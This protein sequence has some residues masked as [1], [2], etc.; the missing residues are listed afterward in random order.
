M[1]LQKISLDIMFSTRNILQSS[2]LM[3]FL[4]YIIYTNWK[5]RIIWNSYIFLCVCMCMNVRWY[6]QYSIMVD[7]VPETCIYIEHDW[8]MIYLTKICPTK[9]FILNKL[10][11]TN[12]MLFKFHISIH[13]W[14]K[15]VGRY[16]WSWV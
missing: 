12:S 13:W 4:V 15:M 9:V 11:N 5:G 3:V 16:I 14:M 2:A 1:N 10:K 7:S 8:Y 6:Y